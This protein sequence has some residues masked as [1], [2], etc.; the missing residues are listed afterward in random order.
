MAKATKKTDGGKF[1]SG[2][3]TDYSNYN[4]PKTK[5]GPAPSRKKGG[6]VK[7]KKK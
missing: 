5:T 7:S 2:V 3:I 6:I 4:A 1:V